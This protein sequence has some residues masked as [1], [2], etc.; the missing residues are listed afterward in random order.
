MPYRE[1][2]TIEV[3][4]WV[5]GRLASAADHKHCTVDDL[6][7]EAIVSLLPDVQSSRPAPR[8][9]AVQTDAGALPIPERGGKYRRATKEDEQ[10]IR[11][12]T[13]QQYTTEQTAEAM[14]RSPMFVHRI[15]A[16]LD[17]KYVGQPPHGRWE[18]AGS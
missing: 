3:P 9:A 5:W 18:A 6:V 16:R 12:M 15:R 8:A 1:T 4:L 17:L 13:L 10:F 7:V 14:G 2:A 11:S